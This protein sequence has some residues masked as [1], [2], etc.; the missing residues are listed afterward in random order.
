MKSIYIL[1]NINLNFGSNIYVRFLWNLVTLVNS[2]KNSGDLFSDETS[3]Y[4]KILKILQLSKREYCLCNK[5]RKSILSFSKLK[6]IYTLLV[7]YY[8]HLR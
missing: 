8:I 2:S 5:K 3:I 1:L 4:N 7:Y 6:F